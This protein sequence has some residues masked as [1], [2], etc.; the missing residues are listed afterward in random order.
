MKTR[1]KV[2]LGGTGVAGLAGLLWWLLKDRAKEEPCTEGER[3]CIGNDLYECI[4]GEWVLVEADSAECRY[5]PPEM[6]LL[7]H[8]PWLDVEDW[9]MELPIRYI[10]DDVHYVEPLSIRMGSPTYGLN[11]CMLSR[12]PD[13][14]N[15]PVG[16][17]DTWWRMNDSTGRGYPMILFR[18]Q[19]PLGAAS[20]EVASCYFIKIGDQFIAIGKRSG[21]I[22][23][24][25]WTWWIRQPINMWHR[26]RFTWWMSGN[27]MLMKVEA[28]D[29][30][31]WL[32][33]GKIQTDPNPAWTDSP[34][35][36]VGVGTLTTKEGTYVWFDETDIYG[37]K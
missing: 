28:W 4:A 23:H 10:L 2:I 30:I 35:N 6:R 37:P 19:T 13:T 7:F 32:Q 34:I 12:H 18:H 29:G 16:Q 36:R 5:K 9:D 21:G 1:D 24:K 26:N 27:S 33:I 14:Q 3:E 20:F 22:T 15:L 25:S 17:V 31:Q 11:L 8:E